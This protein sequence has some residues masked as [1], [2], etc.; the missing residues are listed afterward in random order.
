MSSR[1]V[2]TVVTFGFQWWLLS[3]S[4]PYSFSFIVFDF[5][6]SLLLFVPSVRG[7]IKLFK[8]TTDNIVYRGRTDCIASERFHQTSAFQFGQ[9]LTGS[10]SFRYGRGVSVYDRQGFL[11]P[12]KVNPSI[13]CFLCSVRHCHFDLFLSS[14]RSPSCFI[15]YYL[16][17]I[18][19]HKVSTSECGIRPMFH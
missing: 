3:W 7:S 8:T 12:F 13:V 14:C 15:V 4:Q 17:V 16:I 1:W 5:L 18:L 6:M 2:N 19:L 9:C 11:Y 10:L